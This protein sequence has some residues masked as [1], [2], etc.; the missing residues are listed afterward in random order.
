ME[1]RGLDESNGK[2][3]VAVFEWALKNLRDKQG[4]FYYQKYPYFTNK[5]SYMR[6]SQ[7]WM[8]MALATL[9]EMCDE[10]TRVPAQAKAAR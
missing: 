5:I 2:Q 3:A 1:F 10:E 7:A 6:W 9:R 4:Y 8:L